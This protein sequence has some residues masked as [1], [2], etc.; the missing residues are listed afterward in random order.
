MN[1]EEQVVAHF[2]P[3]LSIRASGPF[4][5]YTYNHYVSYHGTNFTFSYHSYVVAYFYMVYGTVGT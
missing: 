3:V 4:K 1:C 5:A 2:C